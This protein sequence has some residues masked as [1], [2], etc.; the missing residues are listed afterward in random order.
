MGKR[1]E[2]REAAVQFLYFRDLNQGKGAGSLDDFWAM[3]P[4]KPAVRDFA[5]PL[6]QGVITHQTEI[7]ERIS[8][9]AANYQLHRIS[10]VDRNILRLAVFELLYRDDIPPVVS[11]N[12]AIEIAKRYGTDE[13]GR[14]VN[15]I[16]DRIK[17]E[18]KRPLRSGITRDPGSSP[19]PEAPPQI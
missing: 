19:E 14:F 1:R 7:D 18:L 16:L 5:S 9:C 11:I 15:G 6:I 12:E 3:R 10:V 13:S 17:L 2:G 8:R 4:S